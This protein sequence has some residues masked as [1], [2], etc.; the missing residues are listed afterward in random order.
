V[1]EARLA[2]LH[3]RIQGAGE[4]CALVLQDNN[5]VDLI[6]ATYPRLDAILRDPFWRNR[7]LGAFSP[8]VP[9]ERLREVMR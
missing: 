3:R 4:V 8:S 5:T 2:R 6:P 7:V 9:I 1:D